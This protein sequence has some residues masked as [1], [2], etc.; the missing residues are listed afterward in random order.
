M[1]SLSGCNP[2]HGPASREQDTAHE[3]LLLVSRQG[4]E[5]LLK[6]SDG[7][8]EKEQNCVCDKARSK[9]VHQVLQAKDTNMEAVIPQGGEEYV[10]S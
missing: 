10:R 7:G 5:P 9:L 4:N 2:I 6:G 3:R 8:G 1:V